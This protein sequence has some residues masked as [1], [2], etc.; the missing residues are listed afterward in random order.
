ML[1]MTLFPD[2]QAAARGELDRVV[3]HSR[4]PTMEDRASLPY[5]DALIKETLRWHVLLPTSVPRRTEKDD[6]Y[7]GMHRT[8]IL[9]GH[10]WTLLIYRLFYPRWHHRVAQHLVC[11]NISHLYL[12]FTVNIFRSIAFDSSDHPEEFMPERFLTSE[13]HLQDPRTYSFG[14]GRRCAHIF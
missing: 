2:K 4:L 11:T 5:V 7:K 6:V 12:L 14:F 8:P 9:H 3:G 10:S 1:A 13:G